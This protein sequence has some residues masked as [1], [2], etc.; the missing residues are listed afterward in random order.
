MKVIKERISKDLIS[1]VECL[2]SKGEKFNRIYSVDN[3]GLLHGAFRQFWDNGQL[4]C[5]TNYDHGVFDGKYSSWY[6]NGQER[7]MCHYKKGVLH[8]RLKEHSFDG[9]LIRDEVYDKGK[10]KLSK[11]QIE[12][13][14]RLS[15]LHTR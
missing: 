8:G 12:V 11:H 3:Q 2:D 15:Q 5:E 1:V 9:K 7:I 6:G 10:Q 14:Y 13:M 4:M